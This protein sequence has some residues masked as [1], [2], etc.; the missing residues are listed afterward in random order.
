MSISQ[1]KSLMKKLIKASLR[2][3]NYMRFVERI[4]L[5]KKYQCSEPQL[6]IMGLPRSGTTLL[7]QYVVHRLNVAYFTHGVARLYHAPCITTYIQHKIYGRYES[8]FKSNYGKEAGNVSPVSPREAG[9]VWCRFFDINDY[10]DVAEITNKDKHLLQNTVACVQNTFGG[11][12]FVNKNV[13]HILRIAALKKIFP[14]SK[15]LIIDRDLEDVAVSILRGRYHNLPDPTKWWSV[16]PPNYG[17]LKKLPVIEQVFKQCVSLRQQLDHDLSRL[18]PECV[19]R[20]QYNDFCRNPEGFVMQIS[21]FIEAKK[22]NS[23]IQ[24]NF[25]ISRSLPSGKEEKDL[26]DM[27]RRYKS[28]RH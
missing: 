5:L 27:I 25:K 14:H 3:N 4:L 8:D 7:Y 28:G 10:I 23:P 12:P 21:S 2:L 17:K 9:G 24:K 18:E 15:F 26:I 11:V 19:M 16:R 20:I 1:Q 13:K 22:T 6:F